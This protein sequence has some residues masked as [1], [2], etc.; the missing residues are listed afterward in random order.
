MEA[1]FWIDRLAQQA[2]AVRVLVQGVS[3][4]DARRRPAP[5]AWSLVEVVAH[6]RDEERWDFRPRLQIVLQRPEEPFPPIDPEGWVQQYAYRE[7]D[8][9]SVLDGFLRERAVSL[10]WLRSLQAPD[11][12]AGHAAPWGRIRAGDL[13]AAWADHDLHHLRQIVAWHHA[14]L[15]AAA[16]PYTTRYAGVW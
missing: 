3:A 14:R 12:D 11:W 4:E 10:S 9:F 7:Q 16:A 6:L 1:K 5:E 15:E 13:L 2:E 8:L